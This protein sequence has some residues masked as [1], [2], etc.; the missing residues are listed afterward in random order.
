MTG[1]FGR[2]RGRPVD[3]AVR[4][5]RKCALILAALAGLWPVPA[6]S[7]AQILENGATPEVCRRFLQ[8]AP[9][10]ADEER[11]YEIAMAIDWMDS[12]WPGGETFR[13]WRRGAETRIVVHSRVTGTPFFGAGDHEHCRQEVWRTGPD[14]GSKLLRVEVFERNKKG[15]HE[16]EIAPDPERD[17][18]VYSFRPKSEEPKSR[19]VAGPATIESVTTDNLFTGRPQRVMKIFGYGV[20][21]DV[22]VVQPMEETFGGRVLIRHQMKGDLRRIAWFD[23]SGEPRLVRLCAAETLGA[24]IDGRVSTVRKADRAAEAG[25]RAALKALGSAVACSE[26]DYD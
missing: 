7:A 14:G 3:P 9:G 11:S 17:G 20:Y 15:A 24:I 5:R 6:P 16:I 13:Y 1:R 18:Y 22:E 21:E 19:F 12:R 4:L 23:E 8:A 26:L 25:A 2:R 10:E